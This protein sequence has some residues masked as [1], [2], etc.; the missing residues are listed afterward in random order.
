MTAR[1]AARFRPACQAWVAASSSWS[2]AWAT[3]IGGVG[4]PV[5]FAEVPDGEGVGEGAGEL[6]QRLVQ[7]VGQVLELDQDRVQLRCGDGVLGEGV[8]DDAADV[9]G[10]GGGLAAGCRRAGRRWPVSASGVG[11][12]VHGGGCLS[13]GVRI[14]GRGSVAAVEDVHG[15]GMGLSAAPAAPA[16]GCYRATALVGLVVG[17]V[18]G[19]LLVARVRVWGSRRIGGR[20]RRPA[21]WLVV[22]GVGCRWA[23]CRGRRWCGRRGRRGGRRGRG[24]GG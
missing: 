5:V 6:P 19:P 9:L 10:G 1:A 20:R 12:G 23:R 3:L 18:A 2:Q 21:V 24:R 8:V 22:L 14:R 4:V 16:V 7:R 11:D 17:P 15:W 13:E